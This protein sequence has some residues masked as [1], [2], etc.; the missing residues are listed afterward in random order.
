MYTQGEQGSSDAYWDKYR[1]YPTPVGWVA[2]LAEEDLLPTDPEPLVPRALEMDIIE[3]LS[4]RMT[5]AINHY[6]CKDWCF[7]CGASDHFTL[8]C[9]HQEAF[10]VWHKEHL[11]SKGVGPQLKE[12]ILKSPL[13][14]KACMLPQPAT[15]HHWSSVD[16]LHIGW[17]LRPWQVSGS[18]VGRLTPW[19]TVV[20]RWILWCLAMYTSMNSLVNHPLNL[21][22]LGGTKTHPLG[23]VIL[24]VQVNEIAGYDKDVVFLMVPDAVFPA[25]PYC[26]WDLYAGEDRQ[27]YQGEQDG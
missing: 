15:P 18:G 24:R 11:N 4:L 5:Q 16:Q 1:R 10:C 14:N 6:Q 9:P 2:T 19:L 13:W 27:C 17:A 12:P 20:V 22:G 23:F 8:D 21:V 26:D 25:C 3:S 7:V